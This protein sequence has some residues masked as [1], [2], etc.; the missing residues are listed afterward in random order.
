MDR[1]RVLLASCLLL[2]VLAVPMTAF[3]AGG[4]APAEPCVPG[5]VW[6]DPASGVKYLCVYDEVYG[7]S[8]WELLSNGQR[9]SAAT[10][11]RSSTYGCLLQAVGLS[12][13]SGGGADAVSRT[14][15]WPCT[16]IRDRIVQ[17]PGEIRSRIVLQ[18]FGGSGWTS[19]RDSGY[20]YNTSTSFGWLAGIDMGA[21][22]DCGSGSYRAIGFGSFYQGG[23]WRG[24]SLYAPSLWL[25]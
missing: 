25:P 5:T 18:R 11:Y 21:S 1:F 15:R 14:Y 3:A 10:T 13:A 23:L 4:P 16:T 20:A 19:C 22:A 12:G 8:R 9:G 7:G 2:L 24:G 17:P 6:E